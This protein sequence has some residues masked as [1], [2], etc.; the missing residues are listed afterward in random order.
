MFSLVANEPILILIL[1]Y[2]KAIH[3]D[4]CV[5]IYLVLKRKNRVSII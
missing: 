3:N 2:L 5:M 1:C 4:F